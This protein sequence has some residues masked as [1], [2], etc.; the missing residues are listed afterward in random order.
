MDSSKTFPEVCPRCGDENIATT[1]T[2]FGESPW[3]VMSCYV[4]KFKWTEHYKFD[5]WTPCAENDDT[6]IKG[7]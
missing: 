2:V 3:C 4:C 6:P 7:L 1:T 5:F